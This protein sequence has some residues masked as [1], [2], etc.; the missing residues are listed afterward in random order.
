LSPEFQIGNRPCQVPTYGTQTG[1]I[2]VYIVGHRPTL[3]GARLPRQPF[4]SAPHRTMGAEEKGQTIALG[5]SP[6][7]SGAF[8]CRMTACCL[9][10][11]R[12]ASRSRRG[13]MERPLSVTKVMCQKIQSRPRDGEALPKVPAAADG[14]WVGVVENDPSLVQHDEAGAETRCEVQVVCGHEHGRVETREDL[15]EDPLAG[16]I[17]AC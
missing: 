11:V 6:A 5:T 9:A 15:D 8:A 7:A 12:R 4:S 3:L 13:R 16:W 17:E 2:E 14:L 1:Q 10:G